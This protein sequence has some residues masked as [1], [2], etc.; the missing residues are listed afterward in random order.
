MKSLIIMSAGVFA[1]SLGLGREALSTPP[2][3]QYTIAIGKNAQATH[4]REFVIRIDDTVYETRMS[5]AEALVM[6]QVMSRLMENRVSGP[7]QP[8]GNQVSLSASGGICPPDRL[9]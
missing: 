8:Y 4:N 3:T 6:Y 2:I 7:I 9:K 5:P 1:S